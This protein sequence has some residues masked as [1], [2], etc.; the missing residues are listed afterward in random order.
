MESHYTKLKN[1]IESTRKEIYK[2]YRKNLKEINLLLAV[3]AIAGALNYLPRIFM[4]RTPPS[5]I[6]L[7]SGGGRQPSESEL[8]TLTKIED[9]FN[10]LESS[11][12]GIFFFSSILFAGFLKY[13]HGNARKGTKDRFARDIEKAN[14]DHLRK[15]YE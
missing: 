7:A 5:L 13:A 4:D 12:K 9:N 14:E 11:T 10:V 3:G 8:Q 6:D 2:T 1:R 15:L